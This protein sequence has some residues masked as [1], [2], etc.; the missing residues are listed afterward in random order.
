MRRQKAENGAMNTKGGCE[1]RISI[2]DESLKARITT[3]V[4]IVSKENESE[5]KGNEIKGVVM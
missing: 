5:N 2:E 1:C 3:I 4:L